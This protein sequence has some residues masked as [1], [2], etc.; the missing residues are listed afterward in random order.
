MALKILKEMKDQGDGGGS[1]DSSKM[2]NLWKSIWNLNCP[3]KI[4]HFMWRAC[5]NILPTNYCLKK[6]KVSSSDGC[7]L[8]GGC[9]TTVH[10]LVQC[11]VAAEVSKETE[12]KMPGGSSPHMEFINAVWNLMD[13]QAEIDL[14]LNYDLGLME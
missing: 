1:S 6:R 12:I 2:T 4:K 14:E 9:E 5:K 10:I 7:V 3:N 8:C 11:K 13:K